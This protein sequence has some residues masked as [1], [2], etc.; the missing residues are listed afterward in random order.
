[1]NQKKKKWIVFASV[2]LCAVL[3]LG[4]SVALFSADNLKN[5]IEDRTTLSFSEEAGWTVAEQG[6][7]SLDE[8]GSV[9]DLTLEEPVYVSNLM[10]D[11]ALEGEFTTV[12]LT[13]LSSAD[14]PEEAVTVPAEVTLKNDDLYLDVNATVEQMQ[15]DLSQPMEEN[16][17]GVSSV[18]AVTLNPTKLNVHY[19]SLVLI[20]LFPLSLILLL[21]EFFNDKAGYQKMVAALK[22]YRCLLYDLVSRDIKTKYRRS[23]L[24]IF[25][26]VLN[27]LLMMLVLSVI[28]SKVFNQSLQTFTVYYLT[29]YIMFNFVSESTNFSMVSIIHSAGLIK[30]VYIPKIVFPLEK[31]LFSLV[32]FGFSLI[33][34]IIVFI[35]ARVQPTWTML[36]FFIPVIYLFIFAFGFSLILATLNTFFRDVG[37]LYGV[38]VTLWMYLTPII[39][40]LTTLP[41]LMQ[42]LIRI[43]NPL[44]HYV[45]YFRQVTLYGVIPSLEA[46]LICIA[47]SLIFLFI[48]VTVFQ[49]HQNKFIF[50]V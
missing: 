1:M 35:L 8:S 34:A 3:S 7:V 20:F 48:G 33:A 46:N 45:D 2:L 17:G 18:D 21:V 32:N 29:G 28:F 31:C 9:V 43:L 24:G 30:K 36:L 26:S 42:S 44:Y 11:C 4:L 41:A 19:Q 12:T 39:Y 23:V 5:R 27:P 47:Y 49:K 6:S 37:Y 50:Y 13:Y 15:I 25:W 16:V 10:L 22:K 14:K 38:F 40:P